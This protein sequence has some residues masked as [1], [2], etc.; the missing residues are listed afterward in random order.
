MGHKEDISRWKEYGKSRGLGS[1]IVYSPIDSFIFWIG[2]EVPPLLFWPIPLYIIVAGI[3]FAIFWGTTM[4]LTVWRNHDFLT[5]AAASIT[6]G[7]C[8]SAAMA[9]YLWLIKR[10]YELSTWTEFKK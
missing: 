1:G 2:V 9:A 5:V 3:P 7:L 6:A 4:Y 8:W 10:K